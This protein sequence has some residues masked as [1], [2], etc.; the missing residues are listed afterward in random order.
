M[1]HAANFTKLRHE[2]TRDADIGYYVCKNLKRRWSRSRTPD[3]GGDR[4]SR[5][6]PPHTRAASGAKTMESTR[7]TVGEIALPQHTKKPA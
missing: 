6:S 7:G 4:H 2:A 1:V 5:L 3:C